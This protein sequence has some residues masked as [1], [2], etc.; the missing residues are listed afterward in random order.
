LR[1]EIKILLFQL[2]V[3]IILILIAIFL[4]YTAKTRKCNK[5]ISVILIF[6]IALLLIFPVF[7]IENRYLLQVLVFLILLS[8]LGYSINDEFT[9]FKKSKLEFS[10]TVFFRVVKYII[11]ILIVSQFAA[12]FL[13]SYFNGKDYAIEHRI[14]GEYIK[15]NSDDYKESVI[16]SRK[17]FVA[18]YA[19]SQKENV[20]IP[21]TSA[22]NILRFAKA[23]KVDYIVI[24]ERYLSIRD[25][26]EEL[27]NLENYSED[28][29]LVYEDNSIKPIKIFAVKH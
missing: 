23:N 20:V 8:S 12:A 13:Y 29:E 22:E 24:D 15:N 2:E 11:L 26:Y 6:P 25:N 5:N 1:S 7:H 14:A 4:V 9:F 27:A 10:S 16:M 28:V 3:N 17:P 18:F 21:Y 19:N